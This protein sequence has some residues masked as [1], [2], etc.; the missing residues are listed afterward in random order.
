[1]RPLLAAWCLLVATSAKKKS[2]KKRKPPAAVYRPPEMNP[3]LAR[4]GYIASDLAN[5]AGRRD[6]R[7]RIPFWLVAGTCAPCDPA[8][9]PR[10]RHRGHGPPLLRLRRPPAA[11]P[12]RTD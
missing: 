11:V 2:K 5:L 7:T 4:D 1:M 3:S 6:Q 9:T 8:S 12:L 10:R